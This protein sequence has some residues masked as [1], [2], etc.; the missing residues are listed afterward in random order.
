MSSRR[1]FPGP[2]AMI[3]KRGSLK[4][5]WRKTVETERSEIV[6][7]WGEA[8]TIAKDK[9]RWKRDIVAASCPTEGYIGLERRYLQLNDQT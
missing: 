8:Q 9:T 6:L 7:S 1:S 3:S 2:E 4:P 5:T